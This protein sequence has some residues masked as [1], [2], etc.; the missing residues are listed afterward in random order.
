M[1]RAADKVRGLGLGARRMLTT[2]GPGPVDTVLV[3]ATIALLGFGS[4]MVFSAS[5]FEAT[6]RLG[7]AQYYVK[8][9]AIY[10]AL[11]LLVMWLT[12]RF[13]YRKLRPFTYP[14]L[15]LV[16][17]AMAA[18]VLG[19]GHRAGNAYRWLQVGPIH[20]QPSEMAKVALVLW[21]AYSLSK[22]ADQIRTFWVGFVPHMIAVGAL[23]ML[24]LMQPD[25]GSAVV[26][27]MIT[28]ALMFVAG[29]RIS[30]L[31][32]SV[33][34]CVGAAIL[35]V[36][37]SPYRMARWMAFSNMDE[38]RQSLAYQPFQSV[39][40]FGSGGVFGL[41][42]GR[43]YQV[44]Y[45]PESHTDFIA[46]IVGEEL[47]FVGIVALL[48]TYGLVVWRGIAIALAA[49]DDYGT[50]IAFGLSTLL[51]TQVL[52]NVSVALAIVPTKGLTLPFLSYGGSSLLV[53]AASVGLML[54]ISRYRDVAVAPA[55]RAR[56]VAS[57][58]ASALVAT[59]A[60]DG[61]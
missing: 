40:S 52:L 6:V 49:A 19:F 26:L 57:E 46:A 3:A 22:K 8:R 36:R 38:H 20:V 17:G 14:I 9:Q 31:L 35:L 5:S 37:L 42:L 55:A 44:L 53:S 56:P 32:A 61:A 51:G 24:C 30:Y 16:M 11:A 4:V 34:A 25:F 60:E 47:G 12:S 33:S 18:T 10:V 54:S 23:T 7:N 41:G 13:D 58:S 43:G 15:F 45:L 1:S 50:F 59:A 39:M 28:F 27:T 2:S 48:A 21:L 29:G